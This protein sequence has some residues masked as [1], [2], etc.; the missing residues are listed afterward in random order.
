VFLTRLCQQ[1]AYEVN[2]LPADFLAIATQGL[3]NA[4]YWGSQILLCVYPAQK[5]IGAGFNCFIGKQLTRS[6][7]QQ[8]LCGSPTWLHA[9]VLVTESSKTR[10][11][12]ASN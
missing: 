12:A 11:G 4:K 6:N 5:R 3:V 7:I 9:C 1:A 2:S 10:Q 8:F